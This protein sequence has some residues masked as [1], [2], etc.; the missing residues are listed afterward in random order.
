MAP[1]FRLYRVLPLPLPLSSARRTGLPWGVRLKVAW[2]AA[3]G[4]AFLHD[5]PDGSIIFRD[6]KTSNVLLDKVGETVMAWPS[7][8]SMCLVPV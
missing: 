2:Q 8:P 7:M 3:Q 6:F 5:T 1:S 4:L